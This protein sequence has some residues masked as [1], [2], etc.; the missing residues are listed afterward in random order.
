MES[1]IDEVMDLPHLSQGEKEVIL[2]ANATRTGDFDAARRALGEAVELLLKANDASGLSIIVDNYA[3]LE[4]AEGH[5]QLGVKLVGAADALRAETGAE[6]G[7][8]RE[9]YLRFKPEDY[10]GAKEVEEGIAAGRALNKDQ[11]IDLV[12]QMAA[13]H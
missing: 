1:T 12:R 5:P 6:L 9:D 3:D 4:F 11:V 10:L 13:E 8:N 7:A 2:G